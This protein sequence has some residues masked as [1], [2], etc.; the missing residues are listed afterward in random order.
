MRSVRLKVFLTTSTFPFLDSSTY[1][2]VEAVREIEKTDAAAITTEVESI[3][4]KRN[5]TYT[6]WSDKDRY[7]IGKYA[8]E[9]G[10]AAAVRKFKRKFPN[11]N[12]STVWSFR[13][14]SR[15]S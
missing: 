1:G 13:K 6:K 15:Q 3:G 12:E 14:K 9:N 11:L 7:L 4:S 2:Q 10:V 8:S 5:S